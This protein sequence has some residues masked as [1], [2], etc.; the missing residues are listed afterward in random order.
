MH[1]PERVAMILLAGSVLLLPYAAHLRAQ[2]APATPAKEEPTRNTERDGGHDFDFELG[3][4]EIHLQKRLQPLTGSNEWVRFDGTSVT[5]K[6][7]DGRAN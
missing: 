2:T 5:R 3:S 1:T 4:W 7:W 6:V